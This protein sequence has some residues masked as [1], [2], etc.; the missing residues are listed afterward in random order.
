[1]LPRRQIIALGASKDEGE[2]WVKTPLKEDMT[3][4]SSFHYPVISLG[5]DE[6][7]LVSYSYDAPDGPNNIQVAEFQKSVE[8]GTDDSGSG[9]SDKDRIYP[10]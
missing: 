8:N 5:E 1:M 6:S 9:S 2:T 4:L 7:I 3:G 10:L